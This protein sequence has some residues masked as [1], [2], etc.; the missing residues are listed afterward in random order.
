LALL[1]LHSLQF[2]LI[3]PG[4]RHDPLKLKSYGDSSLLKIP[5]WLLISLRETKIQ[6]LYNGLEGPT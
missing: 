4:S 3:I 1:H 5:Q 2:I 6:S